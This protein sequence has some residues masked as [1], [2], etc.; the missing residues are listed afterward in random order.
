MVGSHINE[1]L[2]ENKDLKQCIELLQLH[3][4]QEKAALKADAV[5]AKEELVRYVQMKDSLTKAFCQP[6]SNVM[7]LLDWKSISGSSWHP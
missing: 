1:V 3:S 7:W 5:Q 6:V 4:E 2:Q